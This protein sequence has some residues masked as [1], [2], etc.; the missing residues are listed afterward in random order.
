MAN[1]K[2]DRTSGFDWTGQID[3]FET[4]KGNDLPSAP[5]NH[6]GF[7]FA[8]YLGEKWSFGAD[9]TYVGDYC[10]DL[11]NTD[12]YKVGDY[13]TT[14]ARIQF[15]L[16]NLTINGYVTNLTNEDVVYYAARGPRA[17]VGQTRTIGLSA[18]YRL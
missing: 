2:V 15:L 13:T 11:D 17:S 16:D 1:E 14:D 8:Q 6:F 4:F 7:G 10:S 9:I 12:N 5:K 3:Q 18:I